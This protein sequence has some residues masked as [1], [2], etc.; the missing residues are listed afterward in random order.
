MFTGHVQTLST[1]RVLPA[2][3]RPLTLTAVWRGIEAEAFTSWL[4]FLLPNQ[5]HQI[6]EVQKRLFLSHHILELP[7]INSVI[8]RPNMLLPKCMQTSNTQFIITLNI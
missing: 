3:P 2:I 4:P 6:S 1:C 5:Q 8:L 7:E